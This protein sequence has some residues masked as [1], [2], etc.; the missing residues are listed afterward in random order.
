[1]SLTGNTAKSSNAIFIVNHN[2]P[3]LAMFMSKSPDAH[4]MIVS[5]SC[6]QY[7]NIT[8]IANNSTTNQLRIN[9]SMAFGIS[10]I[11]IYKDTTIHNNILPITNSNSDIRDWNNI[12]LSTDHFIFN[13]AQISYADSNITFNSAKANI[14]LEINAKNIQIRN[15]NKNN[16][17][18]ISTG[19]TGALI[20]VYSSN[21][22][23]LNEIKIGKGSTDVFKEAQS[24]LYF[25]PTRV[26]ETLANISVDMTETSN[27]LVTKWSHISSALST[28]L[29]IT[30]SNINLNILNGCNMIVQDFQIAK[31]KYTSN[32][33]EYSIS[34]SNTIL[35]NLSYTSNN[36]LIFIASSPM[37]SNII[38]YVN[39]TCNQLY[40]Q[41]FN[42]SNVMNSNIIGLT[43]TLNSYIINTSNQ[44][45]S[46]LSAIYQNIDKPT[47]ILYLDNIV[48]DVLKGFS[49]LQTLID[50]SNV[51]SSNYIL[52]TSNAFI[53]NLQQVSN[54]FN[55]ATLQSN[56]YEYISNTSNSIIN[57]IQDTSD[58]LAQTI[59]NLNIENIADSS[60]SLIVNN[61]YTGDLFLSNLTTTGSIIPF[62]NIAFNLGNADQKWRD[63][64]ITGNTIYMNDTIISIDG[65]SNAVSIKNSENQLTELVT[66][67][68]KIIDSTGNI[69]GIQSINNKIVLTAYKESGEI[70]T[71][72]Q[73]GISTNEV[74]EMPGASNLYYTPYR[75][76][77]IINA[78][79]LFALNYTSNVNIHLNARINNLS[80]DQIANGLSYE[81]ITN[82]VYN[83]DLI[84]NASV[85]AS[86][87]NVIG[88]S[89]I[90]KTFKHET[91][92]MLISCKSDYSPAIRVVQNCPYN[93][94]EFSTSNII[95]TND[96]K[97]SIGTLYPTQKLD[98]T[99]NIKFTGTLNTVSANEFRHLAGIKSN[100]VSLEN[101]IS[102]NFIIT[103]NQLKNSF[104]YTYNSLYSNIYL[105]DVGT[106][107]YMLQV[108]NDQTT[109]LNIASNIFMRIIEDSKIN[110][111]NYILYT[112]NQLISN[113]MTMSNN[114]TIM[115]EDVKIDVSNYVNR[116]SD[117]YASNILETSNTLNSIVNNI[118]NTGWTP[119]NGTLYYNNNIGI[120]NSSPAQALDIIGSFRF[121][122]SLNG[123]TSNQINF[124]K[125]STSHIQTQITN[126]NTFDSNYIINCSNNIYTNFVST[127]NA[128]I[129]KINV[130]DIY[131]SNLIYNVSNILRNSLIN[132]SNAIDSRIKLWSSNVYQNQ[133][134]SYNP[135]G[136]AVINSYVFYEFKSQSLLT[137][138]SSANNL[139]FT[140][141]GGSYEFKQNRNSIQLQTGDNAVINANQDWNTH[142][143]F[144]ISGWFN[145]SNLSNNDEL[146]DFS[147]IETTTQTYPTPFFNSTTNMIAW[148]RFE[149]N[150]NDSSSNNR[151]LTST[152]TFSYVS[153]KVGTNSIRQASAS[154]T[155][156]LTNSNVNICTS[157]SDQAFT[158][159]FWIRFTT[160]S[161]TTP[162]RIIEFGNV[163]SNNRILNIGW[164]GS[165]IRF[166]FFGTVFDVAYASNI[167][168]NKWVHLTFT[169]ANR[170]QTIYKDSEIAATRLHDADPIIVQGHF[171]VG[172]PVR[173]GTTYSFIGD[174]DDLRIY[175]RALIREEIIDLYN[176]TTTQQISTTKNILIKKVTTNLSF[177]IDN[178]PVYQIPY[179]I[180]NTWTHILWNIKNA[181]NTPFVRLS[182]TSLGIEQI[183]TYVAPSSGIYTNI[184]GSAT[185]TGTVNISEFRIFT[186]PLTTSIK[187][188]LFSPVYSSYTNIVNNLQSS[189]L[190]SSK[191]TQW[192]S[193][194][195]NIYYTSGNVGIG[196]VNYGTNKLAIYGGDLNI[197]SGN[198]K[199]TMSTTNN[200]LT[201]N[202]QLQ[203][204]N[205]STGY[206]TVTPKFITYT[207][208]NV[209]IK[210]NNPLT[211]LHIGT[212]T[213]S[214]A[215]SMVYFSSTL[216]RTSN[217]YTL[218]NIC[219]TFDSSIVVS[220]RV[221]S[222]SDQRIKTNI[223]DVNDDSA[224]SKILAIQPK[225]Y[226]YIDR[227]KGT[228]NVYGFIAQQIGTI[229]PEAISIQSD[230]IPNIYTYAD[231]SNNTIWLPANISVASNECIQIGSIIDIIY[232]DVINKMQTRNTYNIVYTDPLLN[233][234]TIDKSINTS[235]VFIY[236]TRVNDFHT[237]NKSYIYTM[238]VCATQI[239]ANKLN[240]LKNKLK[241]FTK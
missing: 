129:Q 203:R 151:T 181:T 7:S 115:M 25:T 106:S 223:T 20:S 80:T 92:K 120:G 56:V 188:D 33:I 108:T 220:G 35:Q 18:K 114:L 156:F 32:I 88:S 44:F 189:I 13:N 61:I 95:L 212:G 154:S 99:S 86:N 11:Q 34:A 199:K 158:V 46:N 17:Y 210:T 54:N 209:G 65:Q 160:L 110:A 55:N 182:T 179:S 232:Y 2:Q 157:L 100:L 127:S 166:S 75:A 118:I 28:S 192:T 30:N 224:L 47:S 152:G 62:S 126:V 93:I 4:I 69:T 225:T 198:V 167:F 159:S 73:N 226:T 36:L 237:L 76:G 170:Q 150:L 137:V 49:N 185:N 53:N 175:N 148:Y 128:M 217:M 143:D 15:D 180:D 48:T 130:L 74:P 102:S 140:N 6:N 39:S 111:S 177:E 16:N 235:T 134:I 42:S 66:S 125:G 240:M 45:V 168:V 149:N 164:Y 9:K 135:S 64:Y 122:G 162:Y 5:N 57:S 31:S 241:S 52:S 147:F 84:V 41:I 141:N 233:T 234:I 104:T 19:S 23:L 176:I 195:N 14:L 21:H 10:N 194:N 58:S 77:V 22:I 184:L 138:D 133:P 231:C 186:A 227:L 98:I 43:L 60:N 146:V 191:S 123:I 171:R 3:S 71:S 239:L 12:Y 119:S 101:D 173:A 197:R 178:T 8:Y 187:N 78:S 79:N 200:L 204:W 117:A 144:S 205:S 26:I 218:Q 145:T 132:T 124:L 142:N 27:I 153:G 116:T 81:M 216:F 213:T 169:Y 24:N 211:N 163:S 229:I 38:K 87:L 228:S 174:M 206:Y 94:A 72:I 83:K 196:I 97:L 214:V 67:E 40:S 63:I 112:S 139:S 193:S 136:N 103:S 1:M 70:D 208:G 155:S 161:G 131:S 82:N 37:Y 238:N 201:S 221:A 121:T 96:G 107:N 50:T 236:G 219:G 165:G 109:K 207:E 105:S 85:T 230:I 91:G 68:L 90:I 215:L 89:T 222:S 190:N 51:S 29:N 172:Y 183:Y 202:F 59:K 113:L